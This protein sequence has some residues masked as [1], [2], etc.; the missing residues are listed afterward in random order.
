MFY[1]HFLYNFLLSSSLFCY[2]APQYIS[3]VFRRLLVPDLVKVLVVS[4]ALISKTN[5]LVTKCPFLQFLLSLL[6]FSPIENLFFPH[7]LKKCS[8]EVHS[9]L[10]VQQ[11]PWPEVTQMLIVIVQWDTI[12]SFGWAD[13]C[14]LCPY[15]PWRLR[16][17]SCL[18]PVRSSSVT[19]VML[20]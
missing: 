17:L 12:Q 7:W 16:T 2:D 3:Q 19:T 8:S 13:K 6:P 20:L 11:K 15:P 1:N 4:L 18:W 14:H 9:W 5:I 10:W